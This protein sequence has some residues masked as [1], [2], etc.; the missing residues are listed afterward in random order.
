[1]SRPRSWWW[2]SVRAAIRQ[3]PTLVSKKNELQSM[4]TTKAVKSIRGKNGEL[5][6]LYAT[7]GGGGGNGRTVERLALAELPPAEERILEAVRIAIEETEA[8]RDGEAHMSLL[9]DYYFRR[10]RMQDAAD[11]AFVDFKTA[12][13]WNGQ[14]TRRVARGLGYLPPLERDK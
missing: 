2:A 11:K 9:R 5:H 6:D 4:Q 10:M 13:R 1:M 14:F 12:Q 7:R 3:Y 8:G